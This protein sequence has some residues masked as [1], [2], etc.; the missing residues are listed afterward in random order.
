M[1]V[2]NTMVF[3]MQYLSGKGFSVILP[4]RIASQLG[5]EVLRWPCI[6]PFRLCSMYAVTFANA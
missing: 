6:V 2:K 1:L 5:A 4:R 3:P